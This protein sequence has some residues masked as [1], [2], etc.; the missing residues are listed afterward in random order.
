M[1]DVA[2]RSDQ[3]VEQF[4]AA[5]I[6]HV[7][8]QPRMMGTGRCWFCDEVIKPDLL[9]CDRDCRDDFERERAARVR[10]GH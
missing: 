7:G 4:I 1:S 9:F 3:H 5:A 2:D 8:R 10:A 6:A